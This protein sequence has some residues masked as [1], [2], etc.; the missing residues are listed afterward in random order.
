MARTPLGI[1]FRSRE[2]QPVTKKDAPVYRPREL[3]DRVTQPAGDECDGGL[4]E[5]VVGHVR[6]ETRGWP[7]PRKR[8]STILASLEWRGQG[9][10]P[11][12]FS[13]GLKKVGAG[14]DLLRRRFGCSCSRAS[15]LRAA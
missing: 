7:M 14:P 11:H 8:I 15:G 10:E 3:I 5:L 9:L 6:L 1:G 13:L 12:S 2:A 4:H